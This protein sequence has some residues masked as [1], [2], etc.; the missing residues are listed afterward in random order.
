M[1]LNYKSFGQ[2]DPLVILHGLFGTLDNWQ[3]LA[4]QFAEH[5]TVFIVDFRNHGR[6][7]HVDEHS[8]PLMA[9]DISNFMSDN[10]IYGANVIGHSMGGKAAM[11]LALEYPEQVNR[12]VIADIGM[13]ENKAGHHTIFE[14]MF[15][16]D[17]ENLASR[18]V[19]DK[20]LQTRIEEYGVRQFLLKNLTRRR[21][22]GYQWKMN[23]PVLRK[24]Y[25]EIL[26]AVETET[27]FDNPTL[28]IRGG[29]SDYVKDEDFPAI[30]AIFSDSI[31]ET[32][33]NAGHWLHAEQPKVFYDKVLAFLQE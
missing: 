2:G 20:Q 15:D 5:F 6:S 18:S 17:L 24:N 4:K 25:Q 27:T 28:F 9:E 8:Y 12:L 30:Q 14:A 7:P 22:G 11:H 1:D 29:N 13:R 32:V 21:E 31:L 16:L 33:D 3:T 10:W 23:L 26:A 19:A